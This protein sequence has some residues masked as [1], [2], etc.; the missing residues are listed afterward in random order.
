MTGDEMERLI[1]FLL[2]QQANFQ[3][4]S[5]RLQQQAEED[6][7]QIRLT[8]AQFVE[9][10]K[11]DRQAIFQ[12]TEQAN[13]HPQTMAQIAEQANTD[14]QAIVRAVDEIKTAITTFSQKILELNSNLESV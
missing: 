13:T 5:M 10:A 1:K 7:R 12:I 6:R 8:I 3:I 11:I 14:R 2:N 9:Q 4:E